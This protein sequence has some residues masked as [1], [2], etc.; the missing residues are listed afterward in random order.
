MEEIRSVYI[1]I[2]AKFSLGHGVFC[3]SR[4]NVGIRQKPNVEAAICST[5]PYLSDV[6]RSQLV[7]VVTCRFS[8][9]Q[10]LPVQI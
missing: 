2:L 8:R 5:L 7:R 3:G 4:L 10:S 1:E 6:N 9:I